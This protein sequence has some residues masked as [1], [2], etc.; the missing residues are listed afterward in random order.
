MPND[1]AARIEA[2]IDNSTP[3]SV[4]DRPSK[5]SLKVQ[6]LQVLVSIVLGALTPLVVAIITGQDMTAAG[7]L[8]QF[9][10]AT[11]MALSLINLVLGIRERRLSQIIG[12]CIAL[13]CWY[14]AFQLSTN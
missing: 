14:F 1:P 10:F 9:C 2:P 13:F 3:A 6:L 11:L 7:L 12:S 4:G 5:I 8:T